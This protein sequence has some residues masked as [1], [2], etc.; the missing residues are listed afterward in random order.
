MND[1]FVNLIKEHGNAPMKVGTKYITADY[2]S[3][4][5]IHESSNETTGKYVV[6]VKDY[7][8]EYILKEGDIFFNT[9]KDF[10]RIMLLLYSGSAWKD[11][12]M[13]YKYRIVRKEE[14]EKESNSIEGIPN[15][16]KLCI[17]DKELLKNS[18]IYNFPDMTML[19]FIDDLIEVGFETFS[20]FPQK[21]CLYI[22]TH[23]IIR[24]YDRVP[25]TT[26]KFKIDYQNTEFKFFEN[27][28]KQER[29][30]IIMQ[31]KIK[32]TDIKLP[33]II[34]DL[35]DE[36]KNKVM[37][38]LDVVWVG[39]W[40]SDEIILSENALYIIGKDNVEQ[41]SI[42]YYNQE[43]KY[44][45]I[46]KISYN[47]IIWKNEFGTDLLFLKKNIEAVNAIN[48]D[49]SRNMLVLHKKLHYTEIKKPFVIMDLNQDSNKCRI[50]NEQLK[51]GFTGQEPLTR[52]IE[53]ASSS[54]TNSHGW[55]SKSGWYKKEHA[56]KSYNFYSYNDID[57]EDKR[58]HSIIG[59]TH[60]R[61]KS[62]LPD[63]M[64]AMSNWYSELYRDN[65]HGTPPSSVFESPTFTL[66]DEEEFNFQV[67]HNRKSF[68]LPEE[69]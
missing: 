65:F 36:K 61:G 25:E 59:R 23:G 16:L 24:A 1:A 2:T 29:Q 4:C 42:V 12:G 5:I 19:Q 20:I 8:P 62:I 27:K 43:S 60:D 64:D 46:L 40:N 49:F 44:D 31:S 50:V 13:T 35:N 39:G 57:W 51:L 33:V 26:T 9:D 30:S 53:Y 21:P 34:Y 38:A 45:N 37:N 10:Q 47:N 7:D 56:Y 58:A 32:I 54:A 14:F 48:Y 18:Y 55:M 66:S 3:D 15:G 6:A 22:D 11:V 68:T 52:G 17:D 67:N 41:A 28:Y 63:M 69:E